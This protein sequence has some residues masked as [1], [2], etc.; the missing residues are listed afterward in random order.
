[1]KILY[2]CP[3]LGIPVLGWKGAAAH[4]RGL[5][6]AF[7]RSGHSVV[8]AAPILNKSPWESPAMVEASPMQLALSDEAQATLAALKEFNT[9]LG[10]DN[11]LPGDLRRI[12][13]NQEAKAR[14]SRRFADD[15]P[16]FIY[17]RAALCATA[18]VELARQFNVPIVVEVNAPL[19]LE[20]SRY[21]AT[22]FGEL[23]AQ[24][25][26]WVARNADALVTV[27]AALLD[28]VVELG[29]DPRRVHVIPN[30]VDAKLFRPGACDARARA[31]MGL[32][33]G[34]GPVLG[35]VGG[36]RPWH[37]VETLLDLLERLAPHHDRLRLVIVGDGPLRG[38]LEETMRARGLTRQVVFTGTVAQEEVASMIRGFDMALAPYPKLDHAF[39]FSPLK[40]FE[41]MAC[42]IPV[43]APRIGQIAEVIE[44]GVN[45]LLYPV[46]DLNALVDACRRLIGD[47]ALR[48]RIG[49]AAAQDVQRRYTWDHNSAAISDIARSSVAARQGIL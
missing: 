14:L 19:V 39:Y 43:V 48:R 35:F 37:G 2:H 26:G 45:G 11:S 20:Q 30:G 1:M 9:S 13:Y 27:S 31:R 24:A 33:Q 38:R 15:P 41:Y 21:R 22:G 25:E 23:A 7:I 28:H 12:L 44:E 40:L 49:Q 32:S 10:V 34:D 4:V 42:G 17:E 16:D 29:A 36:L 18:G 5:V 46:G 6:S 47:Q 3:D 8:L